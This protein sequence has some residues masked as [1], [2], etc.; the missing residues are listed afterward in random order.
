[1]NE[2]VNLMPVLIVAILMNIG[3]GMYYN[4]GTKEMA[5]DFKI[6][7]HGIIK[8]AIVVAMFVGTAYCFD[9]TDLSSIG[10][11]PSLMMNTAI[12]T[13]VGKAILSLS[14]ILGIDTVIGNK[15]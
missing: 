11:T 1:M 4:I 10:I 13:Y 7:I 8:A 15:Q 9:A 3:A 2:I 6:L 5:F 14:K 12:I